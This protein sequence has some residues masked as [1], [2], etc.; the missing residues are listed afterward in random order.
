MSKTSRAEIVAAARS[1]MRDRGYAGTSMQDIAQRVGLL[2][3]S[4]YSHFPSKDSLIPDMLQLT[5][6][7][8]L[9]GSAPTGHCRQDYITALDG[10]IDMLKANRRCIG[11]HLAY[12]LDDEH[13]QRAEVTRFFDTLHQHFQQILESGIAPPAARA[14]ARDTI[15]HIEGTTLWL[16]VHGDA[17]PAQHARAHLLARLDACLDDDPEEAVRVL[18]DQVVGD[19]KK[20]SPSERRLAARV[21]ESEEQLL[22]ARAALAGFIEA[23][24]CFKG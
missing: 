20:A 23:E 1:L 19:W 22:Q 10:L 11:F 13:P 7:E 15:I 9:D 21:V 18:L 6:A 8:L 24:S 16:V 12:G 3:G 17:E 2:K 5:L 14:L 4:L